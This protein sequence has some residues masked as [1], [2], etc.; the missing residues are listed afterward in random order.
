VFA[1]ARADEK[2]FHEANLDAK[3]LAV[4]MALDSARLP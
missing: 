4:A 1:A 2:D 3:K